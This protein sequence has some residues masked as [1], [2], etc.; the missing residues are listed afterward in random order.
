MRTPCSA[1]A[2]LIPGCLFLVAVWLG[3]CIPNQ[4]DRPNRFIPIGIPVNQAF[5]EQLSTFYAPIPEADRAELERRIVSTCDLRLAARGLHYGSVQ[6]YQG[7][8]E[9]GQNRGTFCLWNA[10]QQ[11]IEFGQYDAR[12]RLRGV[13][14]TFYRD[15]LR[16]LTT[17]VPNHNSVIV[18]RGWDWVLNDGEWKVTLAYV[19]LEN[20]RPGRTV[21]YI[22][23][24]QTGHLIKRREYI[25]A[26]SGKKT[27]L[28]I[29]Y[30]GYP[31]KEYPQCVEF[32]PGGQERIIADRCEFTDKILP[33]SNRFLV[34]D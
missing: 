3:A 20:L 33:G 16:S 27:H 30:N 1:R 31:S 19:K 14:A 10:E 4:Q 12:G 21:E 18:S 9:P 28:G 5:A 13:H 34:E 8:Y 17:R 7:E 22:F 15:K 29:H 6:L 2:G 26:A 32:L 24:R 25:E 23:E 11:L